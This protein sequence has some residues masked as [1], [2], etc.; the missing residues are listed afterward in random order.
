MD[1][2]KPEKDEVDRFRSQRGDASAQKD[3]DATT[4]RTNV[5]RTDKV[6]PSSSV[7]LTRGA[8]LALVFVFVMVLLVAGFGFWQVSSQQDTI[9]TME[10]QLDQARL[11]I[12]QSKL[13]TARLEGQINQTDA[14]M[15]QSGNELA[16][17]LKF[18]DSEVRKL[19]DVTNKRNKQWIQDNQQAIETLQTS[20]KANADRT[21]GL[22]GE[23]AGL[24]ARDE[25]LNQI[26]SNQ[27]KAFVEFK[28][29]NAEQ[30]LGL[31]SSATELQTKLGLMQNQTEERLKALGNSIA[32]QTQLSA[33]LERELAKVQQL[34]QEQRIKELESTLGSLDKTR[35]QLVQRFVELDGRYNELALEVKALQ[36]Q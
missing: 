14:T 13:I 29:A 12:S 27:E 25:S 18:L 19:W 28:A 36:S 7:S 1:T 35:N 3:H 33:K 2:I 5:T 21:Q 16:R 17:E 22:A 23:V 20:L 26:V 34:G 4:K 15:A 9:Q 30:L 31:S 24:V 11:Y 6:T 8:Q 32:A 10:Q